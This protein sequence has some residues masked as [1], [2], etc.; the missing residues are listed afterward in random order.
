MYSICKILWLKNNRPDIY[1][2]TWKFLLFADFILFKLGARPH[3][4]YSLAARTMAFDIVNKQW[5]VE[6]LACAGIDI[7]KF[8]EPVQSGTAVGIINTWQAADLNL[9]ADVMLVAG[10]HDQPC[11]ALGAGVI[12][13]GLAVDGLGTTECI[14]PAFDRPILSGAMAE[15]YFACVPHVIP[16]MY[17]TYAFTFTSGSVLK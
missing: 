7:D 11:A 14:T 16:E 2:R 12:R 3:T 1:H 15:N 13:S 9:P 8:G 5:S 4:D 10:G 17:V 6:I